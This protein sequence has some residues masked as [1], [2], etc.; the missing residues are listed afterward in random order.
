MQRG[1]HSYEA[2]PISVHCLGNNVGF[3]EST[4]RLWGRLGVEWCRQLEINCK[5]CSHPRL[6][7]AIQK[8]NSFSILSVGEKQW[9]GSSGSEGIPSVCSHPT[10]HV[11]VVYF[12][13][14]V[15]FISQKVNFPE[16]RKLVFLSVIYCWTRK[17]NIVFNYICYKI[18]ERCRTPSRVESE[19]S[20]I[21][22]L[23]PS[24]AV[25]M[26]FSSLSFSNHSV[27]NATHRHS[28]ISED[29]N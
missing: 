7:L 16:A 19:V 29:Q 12:A 2:D 3:G 28:N 20:N 13:N 5:L 6:G 22:F 24:W 17:L 23:P 18:T 25:L 11:C 27:Y 14:C 15:N 26:R 8:G 4:A 9:R 10:P 21:R 1:W